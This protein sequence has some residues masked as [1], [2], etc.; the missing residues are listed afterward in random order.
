VATSAVGAT[1]LVSHSSAVALHGLAGFRKGRIHVCTPKSGGRRAGPFV[2]HQV[3]GLGPADRRVVGGIPV[4]AVPLALVQ[5]AATASPGRVEDALDDALCR[6]LAR[7]DEVE[8]ACCRG[9]AGSAALRAILDLWRTGEL[10]DTVAEARLARRLRAHG[11][12][13][14]RRQ[15]PVLDGHGRLVARVDVA[16]PAARVAVEYDSFRWHEPRRARRDTLVR[17]N[18]LEALGWHV[19]VATADD[20]ADGGERSSANEDGSCPHRPLASPA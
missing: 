1:A 11:L 13:T 8:A 3:R 12:P 15:H 19:L 17:R 2:V 6:R 14:P 7:L 10:P 5:V 16:F 9:R 20:R 4:V 18:R